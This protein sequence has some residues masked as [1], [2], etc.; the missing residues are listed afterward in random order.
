MIDVDAASLAH[1]LGRLR[2]LELRIANAVRRRQ[3]QGAV[4]D[5]R[6]RGLYITDAD[7]ERLLSAQPLPPVAASDA[8]ALLDEVERV[9][10]SAE[11]AGADLRLRRLARTFRLTG[12]DVGILLVAMAPDL[13]PRFERLYAYL[14]DD[15]TRRRA[16]TGLAIELC[17]ERDGIGVARA[18]LFDGGSLRAASLVSIRED[19]GPFLSRELCVPDRVT[20]FLLGVD[21]PDDSIRPLL[22]PVLGA[23]AVDGEALA[24]VVRSAMTTV[25]IREGIGTAGSS[26]AAAA[27]AHAGHRTLSLDLRRLAAEDR[28][29]RVARI[30]Q[31][32]ARLLGAGMVAGPIDAIASMGPGAVRVFAEAPCP[33]IL[34][35]QMAWDPQWSS[36]PPVVI[37]AP[38]LTPG[39]RRTL[40]AAAFDDD[41]P[42][43]FDPVAATAQFRLT[44]EQIGRA[45]TVARRR[46]SSIG[47]PVVPADVRE[48]ARAQNGVGLDRLARRI[49]PAATWRDV[50]VPADT[51]AQLQELAAM[52]TH[53][54]RVLDEWGMGSPTRGRGITALF[55]GDSGTG[56]SL[57]AEVVAHHVGLDLYVVDLS[58]VV[59]KYV[60]ETEKNLDRIFAEADRVNGILVFDEADALFG[61]RS[62]IRDSKDRWANVEIAY[63]LQRMERFDGMAVLTTNLRTN[64]DDAFLRRLGV[65]VDFPVPNE[66][67]RHALWNLNL[68]RGVPMDGTIDV[69]FLAHAFRISGGN[70]RNIVVAAAY[71]AATEDRAVGMPDVILGTR[72]EYQKLGRMC[73]EAEFGPYFSIVAGG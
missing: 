35:G 41:L 38:T 24:R 68:G 51:L 52:V 3:A 37:N 54:D 61:K 59:D 69:A 11:E 2:E 63:L 19:D 50:V 48:G 27:I 53:R 64:L 20:G 13:D 36:E 58:T 1:L 42:A 43:S 33:T 21:D 17:A 14:H 57:S 55:A 67:L 9:A 44:P 7:V 72:R 10:D 22:A 49:E 12:A 70:I 23:D 15:V 46:A 39:G 32:E 30:A 25:Y 40:W 34:T 65:V 29:D 66:R 26:L 4:T 60:G 8:A 71:L 73:V 6:F 62:E 31:R 47:S 18:R 45:A 16:T 5:D 56:K 28:V